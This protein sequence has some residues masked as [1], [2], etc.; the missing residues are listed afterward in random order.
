MKDSGQRRAWNDIRRGVFSPEPLAEAEE[1]WIEVKRESELMCESCQSL[2]RADPRFDTNTEN[3]TRCLN[4]ASNWTRA[5]IYGADGGGTDE[6]TQ[7]ARVA[8]RLI[9]IYNECVDWREIHAEDDL[10]KFLITATL[11]MISGY[12]TSSDVLKQ[13]SHRGA[14]RIPAYMVKGKCRGNLLSQYAVQREVK[15]TVGSDGFLYHRWFYRL[16]WDG[17]N[18]AYNDYMKTVLTKEEVESLLPVNATSEYIGDIFEFWLG[19][20]E[21]G[22]EFPTMFEGWGPNID[23]CL[24]GLEESFWLFGNSCR[25]TETA[26]TKR[27]RSRKAYIPHVEDFMVTK[28]LKESKVMELLIAKEVTRM[29]NILTTANDDK[30]I[31]IEISSDEDV[32]MEVDEPDDVPP[33]PTARRSREGQ[34]SGD[35]EAGGD[36]IEV[37]DDGAEDMGGQPS[38]AKKR[39][40][41]VRHLR[42]Q[43]DDG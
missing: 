5:G 22:I 13:V 27:N 1:H 14:I 28:I 16:L 17:G 32:E 8:A 24:S 18:V 39:R 35:T 6:C 11:A 38:E 19:M 26:N 23:Q 37:D 41:D 2:L 36:D 29:Q 3:R 30:D 9:N 25:H 31:E 20:L 4:C 15:T 10:R 43:K 40:T 33:S 7:D 34:T 21:L 42:D 12:Q